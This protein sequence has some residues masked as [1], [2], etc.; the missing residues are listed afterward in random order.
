MNDRSAREINDRQL[1]RP[2]GC[3]GIFFQLFD[4]NCRF[5]KKQ[6]PKKL[7]LP[8]CLKQSS[9]KFGGDE[10]KPKL[11]LIADENCGGF[12]NAK[13]NGMT[14]THCERSGSKPQKASASKPWSNVADKLGARVGRYDKNDKDFE[15]A[16]IKSSEP[17]LQRFRAKCALTYPTRHFSPLEDEADLVGNSL[18]HHSTDSYLSSSPNSRS[19]ARSIGQKTGFVQ[20]HDPLDKFSAVMRLFVNQIAISLDDIPSSPN[21]FSTPA[22]SS[23]FSCLSS[24]A[25]TSKRDSKASALCL[26][27]LPQSSLSYLLANT[28][29]DL[30]CETLSSSAERASF[31]AYLVS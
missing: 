10:K 31:L 20:H 2:C 18:D 30:S 5:S 14:D 3:V 28:A 25:Q 29:S 11:R 13:N 21:G 17:G 9:K 22:S 24:R 12:P 4:R 15:M 6:F 1:Q 7:L 26:V 16:K 8:A 27:G 19:K 23:I